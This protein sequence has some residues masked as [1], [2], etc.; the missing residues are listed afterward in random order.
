M[1]ENVPIQE[2][3]PG[4]HDFLGRLY[5]SGVSRRA[6]LRNAAAVAAGAALS[7]LLKFG[8]GGAMGPVI[9][10]LGLT[11]RATWT[12]VSGSKIKHV[13]ILCQ[14]NRSFDHYLGQFGATELNG[15][16]VFDPNTTY[17]ATTGTKFKPFHI[18][19]FCDYDPDHGWDSS[20]TKW[21]GGAM[22]G[23]IKGELNDAPFAIGYYK[24]SDHIYHVDLAKSFT[25]ADH[26]F[27]SQISQTL[28]NRLYLWS[29]TSGWSEDTLTPDAS[30]LPF[31]NPSFDSPPPQLDWPTVPDVLDRTDVR[32]PWKSYS[33]ADGSLPSPIGAFNPLI[34]FKQFQENPARMAQATND[35]NTFFT[36]LATGNLPAVSFIVTQAVVSEHPP[37]PPDAGQLLAARVVRALMESTAWGSTALFLTYD[38][39]GGYWDHVAPPIYETVPARFGSERSGQAVGPA[40]RVPMTIVSPWAKRNHVFKEVADH[41]S[42]LKFIEWNF[43]LPTS[44]SDALH[45]APDRRT[46]LSDLQGAFDFSGSEPP[47]TPMLPAPEQLMD[48]SNETLT[49]LDISRGFVECTTTTPRWLLPL[50]G[51]HPSTGTPLTDYP[52]PTPEP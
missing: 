15:A 1:S 9:G 10:N 34:F 44:G 23:W 38:E 41:T 29:G 22:D 20:H 37:A 12:P 50:M 35:F 7:P 32:L 45:I 52:S 19:Y 17:S 6:F 2:W 26:Y 30:R 18:D 5:R 13:V 46:N 47:A 42:V 21:N 3:H 8:R 48:L 49:T 31:N 33:V 16:E 39:A 36:D 4:W 51:L 40:F 28:P 43:N 27:C 25:I 11:D 24:K 14:E